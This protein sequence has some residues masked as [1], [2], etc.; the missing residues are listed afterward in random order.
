MRELD[1]HCM[2]RRDRLSDIIEVIRHIREK[3][4][5]AKSEC[6]GFASANPGPL[7]YPS[8]KRGVSFPVYYS[9]TNLKNDLS[10]NKE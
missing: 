10:T 8:Y 4:P 2:I 1:S 9:P 7:P 6:A 5:H 3:L